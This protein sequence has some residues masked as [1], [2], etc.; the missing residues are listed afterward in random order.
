MFEDC[1]D[2]FASAA[3]DFSMCVFNFAFVKYVVES[4]GRSQLFVELDFEDACEHVEFD[5]DVHAR[6]L[7]ARY[8][9]ETAV[10]RKNLVVFDFGGA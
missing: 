9:E 3:F 5:G 4:N 2:G 6:V 1:H 10:E 7:L 8:V